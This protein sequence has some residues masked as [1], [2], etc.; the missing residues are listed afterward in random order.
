MMWYAVKFEARR[1]HA[2]CTRTYN[3]AADSEAKALLSA[4]SLYESPFA[5]QDDDEEHA[6]DESH[7]LLVSV[8]P[9]TR[10]PVGGEVA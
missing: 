4:S 1:R 3:V 6:S 2:T 7:A 5:G 9:T 10:P 8:T